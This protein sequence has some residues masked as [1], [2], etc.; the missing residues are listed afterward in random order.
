MCMFVLTVSTAEL[1]NIK[2]V[3]ANHAWIKAMQEELYHF[4][5]L[6]VWELVDK[7]FGK[8]VGIKS[9]LEVTAIKLVLLVQK[10]LLLVLKVNVVGIKVTIAERLQLLKR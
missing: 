2:E 5:Q 4:D 10:L 1:T 7:P 6:K 9:L 8:T 3:M